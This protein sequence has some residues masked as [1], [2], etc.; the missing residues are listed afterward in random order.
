MML[1]TEHDKLKLPNIV[2][3]GLKY[4]RTLKIASTKI[5]IHDKNFL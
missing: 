1:P 2:V 4:A 3:I 5:F